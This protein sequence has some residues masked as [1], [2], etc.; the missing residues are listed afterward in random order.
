MPSRAFPNPLGWMVGGVLSCAALAASAG[1]D[2]P[3]PDLKEWT[4]DDHDHNA[5]VKQRRR[6][7]SAHRKPSDTDQLIA[8]TWGNQ[9]VECHGKR[10]RGDGPKS[11]MVKARDLSD[12]AWQAM[13][14]DEAM[15]KVIKQGRDKMPAFDLP[16]S[17]IAGLV[18]LVRGF[19]ERR[20]RRSRGSTEP[21]AHDDDPGAEGEP[22]SP[23]PP[24]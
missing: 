14:T 3:A 4:L 15:A 12:P 1:C 24:H 21:A 8:V 9:C 20:Q 19:G 11:P 22:S 16:D 10:G 13:V 7:P 5:E 2:R 18:E 17:T 23:M 6:T